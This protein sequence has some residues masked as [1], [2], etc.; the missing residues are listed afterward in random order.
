MG[1]SRYLHHQR[2]DL[3]AW[4]FLQVQLGMFKLTGLGVRWTGLYQIM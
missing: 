1:L 4:P 3:A 2:L